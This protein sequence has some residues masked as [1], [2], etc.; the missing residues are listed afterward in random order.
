MKDVKKLF[1]PLGHTI[2]EFAVIASVMPFGNNNQMALPKKFVEENQLWLR[3]A[4]LK[5]AGRLCDYCGHDGCILP[6]Y[7]YGTVMAETADIDFRKNRNQKMAR[8]ELEK[9]RYE[10]YWKLYE[11]AASQN[12]AWCTIRP[13]N[14]VLY[15]VFRKYY[16]ENV[17]DFDDLDGNFFVPS[18]MDEIAGHRIVEGYEDQHYIEIFSKHSEDELTIHLAK[19][20]ECSI[21][22][23]PKSYQ[24]PYPMLPDTKVVLINKKFGVPQN[25]VRKNLNELIDVCHSTYPK[26]PFDEQ[27]CPFCGCWYCISLL[28]EEFEDAISEVVYEHKGKSAEKLVKIRYADLLKERLILQSEFRAFCKDEQCNLGADGSLPFCVE[29]YIDNIWPT[30]VG[31]SKYE[32]MLNTWFSTDVNND[33]FSSVTIPVKILSEITNQ[34]NLKEINKENETV[35]NELK[36]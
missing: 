26:N 32:R 6:T 31:P 13:Y 23:Y 7:L 22:V 34:D 2:R 33:D 8:E 35:K 28:P 21:V 24:G 9:A 12:V 20:S 17:H 36:E 4:L 29:R 3:K 18:I 11:S 27:K 10:Y 15:H 30:V 19:V 25:W 1:Y 16:D 14:C 5:P